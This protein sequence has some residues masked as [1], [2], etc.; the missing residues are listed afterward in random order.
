V[1]DLL[2]QWTAVDGMSFLPGTAT[3]PKSPTAALEMSK[4]LPDWTRVGNEPWARN[5]IVGLAGVS[6]R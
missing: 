5:V 6:T 2:V 3:L 4:H 1:T